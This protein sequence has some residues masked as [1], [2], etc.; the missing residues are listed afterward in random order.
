MRLVAARTGAGAVFAATGP[1]RAM[2][3]VFTD[4]R[5]RAC[6]FVTPAVLGAVGIDTTLSTDT[7][8][9]IQVVAAD[10]TVAA[11]ELRTIVSWS[12][13]TNG[14]FSLAALIVG[15]ARSVAARLALAAFAVADTF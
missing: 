15:H 12:N 3:V 8:S 13:P 1:L 7:R 9:V 4:V 11:V 5:I 10:Q 6:P 14:A 2:P